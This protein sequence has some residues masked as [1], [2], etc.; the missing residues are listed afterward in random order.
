M[1]SLVASLD[2]GHVWLPSWSLYPLRPVLWL[3]PGCVS[4]GKPKLCVLGSGLLPALRGGEGVETRVLTLCSFLHLARRNGDAEGK[5]CRESFHMSKTHTERI[6][7]MVVWEFGA[8]CGSQAPKSLW[9][10]AASGTYSPYACSAR[11]V[12]RRRISEEK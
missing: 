8:G 12:P 6:F 9:L 2:P 3:N 1:V 7:G 10:T 11:P 5:Q 4:W